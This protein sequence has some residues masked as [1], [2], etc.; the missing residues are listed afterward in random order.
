V[1]EI[2]A[3]IGTVFVH[4]HSSSR[5]LAPGDLE[6]HYA[7]RKKVYLLD[8][9]EINGLDEQGN[10]GMIRFKEAHGRIPVENQLILSQSGNMQEAA[11]KL[12]SALRTMDEMDIEY[13]VAELLPEEGLGRAINDRLRRAAAMN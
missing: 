2:E 11:K 7:P 1:E 5:P 13:V 4:K 6:S 8:Q 9:S 12:F 10:I 3:V